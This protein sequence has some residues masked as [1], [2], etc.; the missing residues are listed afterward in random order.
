M[1]EAFPEL[2]L[3]PGLLA[4]GRS[5][6]AIDGT[7]TAWPRAAALELLDHL[8]GKAIALLGGDVVEWSDEHPRYTYDNWYSK[9]TAQGSF[10]SF[11]ARS[12]VE[13]AA[14]IAKYQESGRNIGYVLVIADRFPG[15]AA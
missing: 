3:P 7:E 14:Y 10:A 9:P 2:D 15:R 5:L 11:A 1:A 4:Q 12:Q 8:R 13:T 6:A